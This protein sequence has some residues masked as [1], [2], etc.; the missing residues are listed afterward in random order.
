MLFALMDCNNFYASCERAF[1]PALARRPVVVLSNN[2]GCVIARSQEAKDLGIRMGEPEFKCRERCARAG[3]AVFSSNYTLYGDMSARVMATAGALAP[4]MEVYSID[5]AFLELDGLP[6]GPEPH[7]RM[8]RERVRRDTGIPVS[9]GVAPTKTLAKA[10]NRLAKKDPS[11]RGVLVLPEGEARRE[12]LARLD[13]EDVWGIGPRHGRRLRERGVRTALDFMALPREFVR[14]AMTVGGLH[15]W[16]ELHGTP[17]LPLELA[18]KPKQS[19][20]SSRS[21]GRPVTSLE[22]L[23]EALGQY[24]SR[25]AEKL[26][27]QKSRAASILVFV[28]TN[29]FIEGEP[30]YSASQSQALDPPTDD[31]PRLIAQ[32]AAVLERIFRPGF[33]YKKAGVMLCGIEPAQGAQLSLLHAPDER[34]GRLMA[35][36]DTINARWG[37]DTLFPAA[38]GVERTWRMRQGRRSPRYTT[39]WEELPVARA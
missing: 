18:P 3:V 36:L 37:R 21:F 28:Q 35:A 17:C 16:L 30:Q 8:I 10:A 1:N 38:C 4:R 27:A 39:V 2:D 9:I 6:G 5:E 20:I 12:L 25:A 14:K 29:T 13:V 32:G 11:M 15:T 24:I 23:R 19:I 33:R 31:T 34:G 22:H 7:A 26:R